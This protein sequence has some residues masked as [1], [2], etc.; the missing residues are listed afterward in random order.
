MYEYGTLKPAET[1]LRRGIGQEGEQ[2]RG[3]TNLAYNI[4]IYGNVTMKYPV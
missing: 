4:C 2:W 3:I 1:I